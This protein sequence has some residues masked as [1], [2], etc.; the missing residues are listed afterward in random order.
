MVSA[1]EA[2]KAKQI[3]QFMRVRQCPSSFSKARLIMILVKQ[4]IQNTFA[5]EISLC[6]RVMNMFLAISNLVHLGCGK[7]VKVNPFCFLTTFQ[8]IC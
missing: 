7:V 1:L 5:D 4:V 2:V 3:F 6:A 8:Q